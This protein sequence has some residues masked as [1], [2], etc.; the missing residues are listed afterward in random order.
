[1]ACTLTQATSYLALAGAGSI[2]LAAPTFI[3]VYLLGGARGPFHSELLHEHVAAA[4]RSTMLSAVSLS[5][6]AGGLV[7]TLTLPVLEGMA[8]IPW[9]WALV[10]GVLAASSLLYLAIPDR[11][12][13]ADDR[14]VESHVTA[15]DGNT[16]VDLGG[17][18]HR[19]P[20]TDLTPVVREA[21]GS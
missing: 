18:R 13:S 1:M 21:T 8:G 20:E 14:W 19:L 12:T 6:M 5:L 16:V 3:L 4:Q 11:P 2:A 9:T 7:S 15:V 10:G 17:T